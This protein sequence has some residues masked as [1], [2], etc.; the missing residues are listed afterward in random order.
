MVIICGG[1]KSAVLDKSGE[2]FNVELKPAEPVMGDQFF[3][4]D[5]VG[6][7]YVMAL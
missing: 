5:R 6:A 3:L 7:L 1:G 4:G 2:V